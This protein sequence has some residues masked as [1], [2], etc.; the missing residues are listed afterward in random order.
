MSTIYEVSKLAGVSLATVS[1]VL[2]NS[3]KVRAKTRQKVEAAMKKLDYRPNSIAQSLASNRSNS[4]GILVPELYGPFFGAMLGAIE[5]ELRREG[6][7][8]IFTAGHSDAESEADGIEFLVSRKCDALILY[9]FSVSNLYIEL[10]RKS[11]IP[12]VIIGRLIPGMEDD[13][14]T[15]DNE[16]GGYLATKYL[17][18]SGH[19][20]LAC[21]SG[22]LWKSD[23]QQRLDG[24]KRALEE[25]GLAFEPRLLAE[26]DYEEGSGRQ[27][28]RRLLETGIPFSGLVCGN[29][30]MAAGAIDVAKEQGVVIPDD[31]SVVGFD[32][33]FFTRYMTPQLST[34][35]YPIETMGKM[36]A[37]CVLRDFYDK[38]GLDIQCRFEPKLVLRESTA[39][40]E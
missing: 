9:V 31:L 25:S 39:E 3:D 27:G 28:M 19:R 30:V 29:D 7:H 38:S 16:H 11:G 20:Q 37:R 14:V 18:E 5:L 40:I 2:N 8:V 26:G 12:L 10:L 13:C 22:P 6:K 21:I 24:F 35:D 33:V 4:V 23:G 32:N 36:A 1:R 15:L 34:V 17:I